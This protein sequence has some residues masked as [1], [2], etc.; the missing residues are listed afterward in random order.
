MTLNSL[1]ASAACLLLLSACAPAARL[2][3]PDVRLP[4]AFEAAPAQPPADSAALDRWWLLF[5]DPQLNALVEQALT[6][7]PDARAAFARL[8]QAQAI[9]SAALLSYNPQGNLQGSATHSDT[10]EK[11]SGA[12]LTGIPG[13]PSS[14]TDLFAPQ[15][16][17]N[18]YAAQFNVSWELDLFGRRR[19]AR[20]AAEADL[21]AARFDYEATRLSLSANVAQA[22]FQA[23]GLAVQ[24]EEGRTNVRIAREL[25][26]SAAKKEAHGLGTS[27]DSA[28]LV[29]QARTLEAQLAQTE[30][31]LRTTQRTLLVLAGQGTAPSTSAPIEARLQAPP[32]VPAATPGS[33]LERRPDVREAEQRLRSAA[34]TLKL[35]K[36]ALFPTFT[37]LPGVSL[38][39]TSQS[40]IATD[41]AG[42]SVG[43]GLEVPVLD[44]PRLLAQIRAQRAVG[45]QAVAA[46]E[47]AVQNAYADAENGLAT[48]QADEA[49]VGLLTQAESTAR[50]GFE[51][52]QR[53]YRAGLTDLT[54]L[55]QAE[56]GWITARASLTSAQ[57]IALQDAV[58][59]FKALGGGWTPP[60]AAASE[61][62]AR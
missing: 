50:F 60:P 45:E 20:R 21:A 46:Y 38:S 15:G 31:A 41:V 17:S 37:L 24:I 26:D 29:S 18:T 30:A 42:W 36:L 49:R 56:Q 14:L 11:I 61:T 53:G 40:S 22:L 5:N 57:S 4:Q 58:A 28:R 8:E 10:H 34:G 1:A 35:D 13:V 3:T 7:S 25:A 12:N 16:A 6:N 32:P 39:R 54:T 9:R 27:A 62:R 47:K 48:L 23:R 51:A 2:S 55:V 33:L 19:A 44:R 52:A 43:L 59:T